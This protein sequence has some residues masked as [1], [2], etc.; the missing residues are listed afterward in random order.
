M[1][2]LNFD[3]IAVTVDFSLRRI[4]SVVV[5]LATGVVIVVVV[6]VVNAKFL[7]YMLI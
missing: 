3:K 7:L 2:K 1:S 6:V 4:R 5:L